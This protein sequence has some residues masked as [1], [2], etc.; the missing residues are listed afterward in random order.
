[1]SV[2]SLPAHRARKIAVDTRLAVALIKKAAAGKCGGAPLG[3]SGA[4]RSSSRFSRE[5]ALKISKPDSQTEKA[6]WQISR[7][8]KFQ[9]V[10]A[11]GGRGGG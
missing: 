6:V 2:F 1:M 7:R 4:L 8:T 9:I 5:A 10:V 3:G 11:E